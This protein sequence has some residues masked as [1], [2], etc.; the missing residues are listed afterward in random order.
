M[1]KHVSVPSRSLPVLFTVLCGFAVPAAAATDA[2][3][4]ESYGKLPLHFEANQG[5]THPDVRFLSRGPGYSL[6][7][8]AGEAVLVLAQPEPA[9]KREGP[10]K[11]DQLSEHAQVKSVALR[12][13]LVGAAPAP[14][15]SGMD[16]QPG[17]A[18]YFIGKDPA[19]WRTNVPTYAKVHYREV[20]PGIDLVYYGNQRQLEYD[21]V[22]APGANPKKIVLG[23]EGADKLEIDAEGDLVLH[24]AGGDIR[25]KKPVIYQEIDGVRQEIAGGYAREGAN[26]VGFKV[27]AYDR[28]RPLVIDPVL[29]YS[30]YL[31]GT[32]I[33]WAAGIA[34]DATGSAYV[35]GWTRS[36]DFPTANPIQPA[37]G[38]GFNVGVYDAFVAK[39][40]AD[41]SALVYSTYLG[42]GNAD[43][44]SGIAVDAAGNAYV[45]GETYSVNF[46]TANPVQATLR[47]LV[48]AFI[49]KLNPDGS[50]LVYSTYLGGSG[51]DGASGGDL[52]IALDIAGNAY[53]TGFTTSADFPT[54]NPIQATHGGPLSCERD[55]NGVEFC[56]RGFDAFLAKLNADGSALVYATYLGGSGGEWGEGIAV[57]AAGSAYLTGNTNSV[58]FPT[59]NPVQATLRGSRD[60]FGGGTDIFVA[61]VNPDGSALVYSTYLGGSNNEWQPR[62]A[63]DVAGYT[64]VTGYTQSTDFPT[65]NAIQQAFG[66]GWSDAFVAK[67]NAAGSALVYSTY[68]GGNNGE[69]S[70]GIAVDGSGNAYVAGNTSSTNF[71]TAQPIQAALN[72]PSDAFITKL[73][74]DGSALVR[75]TYLGG[76]GSETAFG[77]ALDVAGSVYVMGVTDSTDFP[78]VNPIQATRAGGLQGDG[79]S[80][81]RDVFVAKIV[82]I[83]PITARS[84]QPGTTRSEESAAT[85]IVSWTRYGA[86]TGTFSGGTV[87][88]SEVSGSTAM[89]SFTGTALNWIGVKCNVCG[90]AAVSIDG[91]AATTVDTAGPG[92]PGSLTSE[93][94]FSASGLAP[95]ASHTMTITVTGTTSSGGAHIAVDAFDVTR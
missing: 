33:E 6:Y 1:P 28:S 83:V 68:L 17:K 38:G 69:S 45:T 20:Y 77:I 64:Y 86:E 27:A 21:F 30:T 82:D 57:D 92:V 26:R 44:G 42:G 74:A 2:R 39:L 52:C 63:V 8:T 66:G 84:E 93:P 60:T 54:V 40:N 34:V 13:A 23:F 80:Q 88:A 48:D 47:G 11:P 73:N 43:Y 81:D 29:A 79:V 51:S 90:I 94:V 37:Y 56:R 71:P 25:L 87:V 53:V 5:Q 19:K 62:V 24:A 75:S 9:A 67:L 70:L 95:D 41:G 14:R 4:S 15:V 7:L 36:A 50:A 49:T 59:A 10:G 22:V 89:F 12:M 85:Y 61:K 16:E 58:N 65:V 46:P 18:N 91:G 78:T 76:S 3:L 72:G 32:Q 55:L 35:T 31:G